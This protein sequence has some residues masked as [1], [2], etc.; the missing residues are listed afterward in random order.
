MKGTVFQGNLQFHVEIEGESWTPGQTLR[1]KLNVHNQGTGS[2][3]LGQVGITL[4]HASYK[5][6]KASDPKAFNAY[7]TQTFEAGQELAP[8]Q[9]SELAWSIPLEET[10]PITDKAGSLFLVFGNLSEKTK[11]GHLLITVGPGFII[12]EYLKIFE[13]FFRF[14][15]KE[16]RQFKDMVQIK[17]TAPS[18]KEFSSTEGLLLFIKTQASK[19]ELK[20]EFTIKKLGYT[21]GSVELEKNELVFPYSLS[22]KDFMLGKDMIDQDKMLVHFNEVLNQVKMKANY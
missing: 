10:A 21:K 11:G 22:Y 3:G 8:G 15:A 7:H 14:K 5:K 2:V 18:S 6:V 12:Q 9:T 16:L 20:Y 17:M 1:G 4:A 13:N 19:L